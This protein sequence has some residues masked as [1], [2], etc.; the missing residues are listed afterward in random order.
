MSPEGVCVARC[1][2]GWHTY[3]VWPKTPNTQANASSEFGPFMVILV[4][5]DDTYKLV[6]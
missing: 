3:D 4:A 1:G 2:C 6:E 5:K